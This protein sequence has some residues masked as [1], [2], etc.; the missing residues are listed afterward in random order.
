ML[1]VGF[2]GGYLGE[3]VSGFIVGY[4][5]AAVLCVLSMGFM[6]Q[7]CCFFFVGVMFLICR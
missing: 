1:L 7:F 4:W 2:V 3:V 5:S 6:R